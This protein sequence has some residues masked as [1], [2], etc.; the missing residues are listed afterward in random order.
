[1]WFIVGLIERCAEQC[2]VA[3]EAVTWVKTAQLFWCV[4][5]HLLPSVGWI[6]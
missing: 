3:P 5:L 4:R 6:C 1:M 2:F